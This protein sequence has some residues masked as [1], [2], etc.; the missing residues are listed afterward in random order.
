MTSKDVDMGEND[1]Y[2]VDY[3]EL[4]LGPS[5]RRRR[6][7][8]SFN[9]SFTTCATTTT[10]EPEDVLQCPSPGCCPCNSDSV[11]GDKS[12][13]STCT[14]RFQC[15][16][17]GV[18]LR[19]PQGSMDKSIG[20]ALSLCHRYGAEIQLGSAYGERTSIMGF[21]AAVDRDKYKKWICKNDSYEFRTSK[22]HSNSRSITFLDRLRAAQAA[23]AQCP[24]T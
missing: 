16:V 13:K 10:T 23:S 22:Y 6:G 18:K 3:D 4:A 1:I 24:E 2:D 17:P 7:S 8:G 9:L 21:P 15:R 11:M 14:L 19:D 20:R 5:K 12:S